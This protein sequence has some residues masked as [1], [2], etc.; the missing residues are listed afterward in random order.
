[1]GELALEHLFDRSRVPAEK[2]DDP[3]LAEWEK[4]ARMGMQ[5]YTYRLGVCLHEAAHAIYLER[6]GALCVTLHPFISQY[7]PQSDDFFAAIA[8]VVGDFGQKPI[9]TDILSMARWHVAGGVAKRLL[10]GGAAGRD[11]G[12]DSEDFSVFSEQA[13]HY[14]L[15]SEL[16]VNCWEQAKR[17]V[18]KD[19]RSPA[20]R[21]QLWDRAREMNQQLLEMV[22]DQE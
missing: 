9:E 11:E 6:A 5:N 13:V 22:A 8:G 14:G 17:D 16:V 4:A 12:G 3:R 21:R 15:P 1:M 20:F 2:L 18:E 19:L 7:D 10:V